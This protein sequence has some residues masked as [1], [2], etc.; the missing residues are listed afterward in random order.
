MEGRPLNFDPIEGDLKA[1]YT[2]VPYTDEM[3]ENAKLDLVA[4]ANPEEDYD[5]L[6]ERYTAASGREGAVNVRVF[7]GDPSKVTELD[8]LIAY[9]QMFGTGRLLDL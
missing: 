5:G 7:D 4:Q 3:I 1:L 6:V 9:M 2:G 8:A